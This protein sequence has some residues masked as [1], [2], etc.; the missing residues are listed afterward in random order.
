MW[1]QEEGNVHW[2]RNKSQVFNEIAQ[3]EEQNHIARRRKLRLGLKLKWLVSIQWDC[4][5]SKIN[6]EF[7]INNLSVF[8]ENAR[9]GKCALS[10]K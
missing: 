9:R 8:N 4:N 6:I 10:L 2:V 3:G 7:E 1:M 5:R